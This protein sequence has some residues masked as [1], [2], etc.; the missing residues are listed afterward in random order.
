MFHYTKLDMFSNDVKDLADADGYVAEENDLR[1]DFQ[2]PE[3]RYEDRDSW[4]AHIEQCVQMTQNA[5]AKLNNWQQ[6]QSR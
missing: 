4:K 6:S 5:A 2:F 1:E 3:N